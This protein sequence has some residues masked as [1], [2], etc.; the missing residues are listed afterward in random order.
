MGSS[1]D[2]NSDTDDS[3]T[4]TDTSSSSSSDPSS[5][6]S[7]D[8]SSSS[9]SDSDTESSNRQAEVIDS[10]TGIKYGCYWSNC[11]RS[12]KKGEHIVDNKSTTTALPR[13]L[14]SAP[15]NG[16]TKFDEA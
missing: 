12:C 11:W 9:S 3:D 8:S 10:K 5:S 2:S 13:Q 7:S 1:S 14:S 15:T 16:Q 6:S 4:D